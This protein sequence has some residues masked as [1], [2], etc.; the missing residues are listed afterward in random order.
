MSG[1][2]NVAR[3]PLHKK[4]KNKTQQ[5][6]VRSLM[7]LGTSKGR[8]PVKRARGAR[9]PS[10]ALATSARALGGRCELGG[11]STL[12]E[13]LLNALRS[14]SFCACSRPKIDSLDQPHVENQTSAS[15]LQRRPL[16]FR[17][18][19]ANYRDLRLGNAAQFND[20]ACV[21]VKRPNR[22]GG[23]CLRGLLMYVFACMYH[24]SHAKAIYPWLCIRG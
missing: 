19:A 10:L 7:T 16:F 8:R 6:M 21:M 22:L 14:A 3:G 1:F 13:R 9:C 17:W 11:R 4:T 23:S 18:F 24:A 15:K 2:G 12:F 20:T 5:G